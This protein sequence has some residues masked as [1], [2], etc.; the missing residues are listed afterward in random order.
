MSTRLFVFAASVLVFIIS[1]CQKDSSD[2]ANCGNFI[3]YRHDLNVGASANDLLSSARYRSLVVELQYLSDDL[4]PDSQTMDHFKAMLEQHLNKPDGITFITKQ[5][6]PSTL[7][8]GLEQIKSIEEASRTEFTTGNKLAVYIL[9]LNGYYAG[10]SLVLGA[11][12]RNTSIVA[13]GKSINDFSAGDS[14]KRQVFDAS[15]LEHEFGHLLGL[16][17]EGTPL[18]SAHKDAANGNHCTNANCLM[19][20]AVM[21][22]SHDAQYAGGLASVPVMDSSCIADLRANGGK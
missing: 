12:Y 14:L 15:V 11:A 18:Q 20:Y 1:A 5:I 2:F 19:Y 10:D 3:T 4:K 7:S 16:V 22:G 9:Y 21:D 8:F 17:D 13:F 6:K